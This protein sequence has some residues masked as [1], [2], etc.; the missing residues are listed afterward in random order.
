ME[1]AEESFEKSCLLSK[2]GSKQSAVIT[3]KVRF[4]EHSTQ[5]KKPSTLFLQRMNEKKRKATVWLK[6]DVDH[7]MPELLFTKEKPTV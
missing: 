1:K 5:T 6:K 2:R 4:R 7:Y 3:D